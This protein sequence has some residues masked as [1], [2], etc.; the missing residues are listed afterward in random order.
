M[1]TVHSTSTS[2]FASTPDRSD[3]EPG[4]RAVLDRRAL[5][6]AA[7]D[8]YR[9]ASIAEVE[10]RLSRFLASVAPG[11]IA[12]GVRYSAAARPRNSSTLKSAAAL[13]QRRP[14]CY[15]WSRSSRS[16][17]RTGAARPTC[18]TRCGA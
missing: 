9:V 15:A 18:S 1:A 12:S 16:R 14:T 17:N 10:E 2:A 6:K 5:R 8:V 11:L 13:L 3:L 4:I 7:S